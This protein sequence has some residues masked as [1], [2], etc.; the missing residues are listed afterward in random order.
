MPQTSY[1]TQKSLNEQLS[2]LISQ[3]WEQSI[4]PLLPADFQQAA[5]RLGAYQRQRKLR[6]VTD[7]LRALLAFVLCTSSLRQLGCWAVLNQIA[8]LSHVAWHKRLQRS[9]AW[10]CWLLIQVLALPTAPS[11]AWG[12][13]AHRVV[14]VD[15][16]RLKEPGGCGDDWRGHLAYDVL[17][18][19]LV[20]VRITDRHTA[21]ALTFFLW[22]PGD[23]VVADRGYSR[24]P[25]VAWV[26][27]CGADILVRLAVNSFPLQA[28]S[29]ASFDVVQW[30]KDQPS[31]CYEQP[32]RFV[33]EQ[34]SFEGRIIAQSLS[35]EAAERARAKVRRR[36]SKKQHAVQEDTLLLAGW[37]IVLTSLPASTW[38]A[39]QVLQ[40][41]RA[42][43][44]VE[45]V[46]KRMKQVLRLAQLRGTTPQSNEA[47]LLALLLCWA[48]QQGQVEQARQVIGQAIAQLN[49]PLTSTPGTERPSEA[50]TSSTQDTATPCA[51]T[52]S[53]WTIHTLCIQTWRVCVQGYWTQSRLQACWPRLTRFLCSRHRQRE[54]Q[55][56]A[57]RRLLCCQLSMDA[58]LLFNCSGSLS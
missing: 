29:G 45:L 3:Q 30:L 2:E 31:G 53:S 22:L 33:H 52:V 49:E 27:T 34:R 23:L 5:F 41:Y 18:A 47:T 21:E 1:D 32:V 28:C 43:W 39:E 8:D 51:P 57:I 17:H 15:G 9:R 6:C 35:P 10:L 44:Q 16:T 58:S 55:E 48:L 56:T 36:A 40:V 25:Q 12:Q 50:T 13:Q 37:V 19:R 26:L 54:H 42:R 7:L 46:I 14:L 24:R 38:S 20:D 4:I 11:T